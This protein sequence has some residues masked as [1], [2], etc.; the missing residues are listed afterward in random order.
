MSTGVWMIILIAVT[1]SIIVAFWPAPDRKGLEMWT[2]AR[3]HA[4]MYQPV[5]DIW[6]KTHDPPANMYLISEDAMADRMM[7]GF[8]SHTPVADVIEVEH[9]LIGRVF[10]GPVEDVGFVDLTETLKREEIYKEMNEPSF[11][12]WTSRGHIFGLPHDVHPVMLAYRAD[13]VEKA[14]IDV[15]KIET[16]DDFSRLMRPLLKDVDEEGQPRHYPLNLWYTSM[17]QIEA[18]ILQ[19]GGNLFDKDDQP[20]IDSDANARVISTVI[21]W[22]T[23]PDRIAAD[24]PEFSDSGNRL[25]LTGYVVCS[26]SPD[27]LTGLW[28]SDIPQLKGTLKLMP[29]PAWTPGGRRT[30]V[31]GGTMLGISKTTKDFEKTWAFARNL[32]LND[33]VA[34][35][36][37]ETN[38]IIS[39]V[40]RLW[41]SE[42]YD[43]PDPYF[44]GQAPGRLYIGL[45]PDVPRRTSSPYNSIARQRV[46]SALVA[47][48]NYALARGRFHPEELM[49]EAHLQLHAA[50]TDMERDLSRNVFLKSGAR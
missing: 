34:R 3:E 12:A 29:L 47:L 15:S 48:R 4:L 6:N 27:W 33:E 42:F 21:S 49:A 31:W 9:A 16:W 2:Y 23:G 10:G 25:R 37:Y 5:I 1:S 28:K 43:H 11:S 45:A 32:Y 36:L 19:A 24:A 22:T 17:D 50:Q 26:L 46:Q 41:K 7:S 35:Q 20:V 18:L 14:G 30:S 39:P 13:I 40:K 8:L 44:S 38:G